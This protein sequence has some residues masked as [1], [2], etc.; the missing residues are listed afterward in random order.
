MGANG[1][2]RDPCL[3]K[4]LHATE[5][6]FADRSLFHDKNESLLRQNDERRV[7]QNAKS[8]VI[9]QGNAKIIS[10]ADIVEMQRRQAAKADAKRAKAEARKAKSDAKKAKAAAKTAEA[11]GRK[12]QV[13]TE[14]QRQV[15]PVEPNHEVNVEAH[16]MVVDYSAPCP[17]R[18]PVAQMW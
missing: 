17:N 5:K 12:S 9:S 1:T 14:R 15:A 10:S 7:R 6:A 18:A 3:E 11:D 13:P 16:R 4:L 2:T 8:T